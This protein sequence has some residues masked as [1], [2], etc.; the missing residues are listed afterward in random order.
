M[1]TT[2]VVNAAIVTVNGADD[3]IDPGWILIEDNFI[4]SLGPGQPSAAVIGRAESSIDCSGMA[5]MPGMVNAHTHLFQAF[6]RGLADDKPLLEWLK[7]C[8]WPG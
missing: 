6:F 7:D 4:D 8:I 1:T 2:L 5:V 3:V